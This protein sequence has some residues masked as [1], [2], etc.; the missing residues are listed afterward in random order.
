MRQ[1]EN[2]VDLDI[3]NCP[4]SISATE[5]LE[6]D[7]SLLVGLSVAVTVFLLVTLSS[8]RILRRK[9]RSPS[10]YTMTNLSELG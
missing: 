1:I 5:M 3:I 6:T 10:V 4:S 8:I 7:F 2:L 9:G